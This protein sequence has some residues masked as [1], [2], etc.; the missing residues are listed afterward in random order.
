MDRLLHNKDLLLRLTVS[1]PTPNTQLVSV[2]VVR[3]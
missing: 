1:L 3:A 2:S